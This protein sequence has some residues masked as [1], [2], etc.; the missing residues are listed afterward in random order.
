[1]GIKHKISQFRHNADAKT[2]F[3]NFFSLSFLQIAGYVFPFITLPYLSRVIGVERF[4]DI[5]FAQAIMLYCQAVVDFGFIYSA[6]RDIARCRDDKQS[7]SEI[8]STVMWSRFLLVFVSFAILIAC[9]L[10][11]GKL[12]DMRYVLLVSFIAVPGHAMFPDWLFQGIEK[13]KYITIFSLLM[14]L[15]FT[16]L[17][18]VLIKSPD[19]YLYQPL[20]IGLG[21]VVSGVLAMS[22]IKRMGIKLHRPQFS[23]IKVALKSNVDLFIN[24]IVPNLYNSLST[25]LLGFMHGSVANGIFDAGNRFNLVSTQFMNVISRTFFPYLSRKLSKHDMYVRLHLSFSVICAVALFAFAPLIIDIF[26]S[27]EYY[28]AVIVLRIM[29]LSL[30]F[31]SLD[32]IYGTNYLIVVGEEK[33]LR[34]ITFISSIIGFACAIPMAYYYSYIGVAIVIVFT[35]S[36]MALLITRKALKIK[37]QND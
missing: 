9:I 14:K 4:G 7:V 23:K 31:L 37:R 19:D 30:I 36:L 26:F 24:Q 5:A 13:M 29:S 6:V 25:I 34:N 11:I 32:N 35:R 2:L 15:V 27:K 16:I 18:F 3:E 21:Y 12:Y 20:L 10:S 33:T 8:Y 28:D 22:L 1:M 17:V